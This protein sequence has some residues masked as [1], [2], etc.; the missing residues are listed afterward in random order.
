[1]YAWQEQL[2]Q[3]MSCRRYEPWD[4]RAMFVTNQASLINRHYQRRW[5]APKVMGSCS[6][7]SD[8]D[9]S[10]NRVWMTRTSPFMHRDSASYSFLSNTISRWYQFVLN[11]VDY[12]T[13]QYTLLNA[14]KLYRFPFAF[15]FALKFVY[16]PRQNLFSKLD[17]IH[18]VR[19]INSL[20]LHK[21]S[22]E[23]FIAWS[24]A[25]EAL[26]TMTHAHTLHTAPA[27]LHRGR[28]SEWA[29]DN[30]RERQK[31]SK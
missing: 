11:A 17:F 21:G 2:T 12:T 6:E 1:M 9:R 10:A 7:T 15:K 26:L 8:V 20:L 28:K 4:V 5:K 30:D 24:N 29:S 16:F 3:V 23:K 22:C 31:E 18:T 14:A 27:H 25:V 19:G 13:S